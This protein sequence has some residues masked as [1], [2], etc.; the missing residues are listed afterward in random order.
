MYIKITQQAQYSFFQRIHQQ[1]YYCIHWQGIIGINIY[2]Y[3]IAVG[4]NHI[5]STAICMVYYIR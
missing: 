2:D 4:S 3:N 5:T 1:H